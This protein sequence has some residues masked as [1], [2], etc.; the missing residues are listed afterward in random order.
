MIS[1]CHHSCCLV[2]G[3]EDIFLLYSQPRCIFHKSHSQMHILGAKLV[4]C[5]GRELSLRQYEF[6]SLGILVMPIFIR[7][8]SEVM[9]FQDAQGS[10]SQREAETSKAWKY[11]LLI[12]PLEKWVLRQKNR[13]SLTP[14]YFSA[15]PIK[16]FCSLSLAN[17]QMLL[18]RNNKVQIHRIFRNSESWWKSCWRKVL[19][20]ET[21]A[22][23]TWW[24]AEGEKSSLGQAKMYS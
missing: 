13:L 18:T 17:V 3:R 8:I 16:A 12:W 4:F 20:N 11:S 10:R 2:A 22:E 21:L 15:L 14:Q 1:W 23:L 6:Q 5:L 9:R 19:S 7:G 24:T